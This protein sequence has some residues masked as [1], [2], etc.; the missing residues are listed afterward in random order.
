[1]AHANPHRAGYAGP[2]VGG[3]VGLRSV[4]LPAAWK[5]GAPSM[6]AGSVTDGR[7]GTRFR[8]TAGLRGPPAVTVLGTVRLRAVSGIGPTPPTGTGLYREYRRARRDGDDTA[9]A[10]SLAKPK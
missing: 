4:W 8:G 10:A 2:R 3:V 7:G 1:M 9:V 6:S 5:A